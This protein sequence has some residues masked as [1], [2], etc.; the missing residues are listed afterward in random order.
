M[1]A[2]RLAA[3]IAV[4]GVSVWLSVLLL[5]DPVF[6]QMWNVP[7]SSQVRGMDGAIAGLTGYERLRRFSRGSVDAQ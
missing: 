4:L 2:L 1:P 6:M 3:A 5:G 7:L